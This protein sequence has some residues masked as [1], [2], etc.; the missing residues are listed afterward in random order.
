MLHKDFPPPFVVTGKWSRLPLDVDPAPTVEGLKARGLW[1]LDDIDADVAALIERVLQDRMSAFPLHSDERSPVYAIDLTKETGA[2]LAQASWLGL[3]V[4]EHGTIAMASATRF[5]STRFRTFRGLH[6]VV[7]H[8]IGEQL[9]QGKP[10]VASSM[11]GTIHHEAYHPVVQALQALP[12]VERWLAAELGSIDGG[13]P[14]SFEDPASQDR[15]A[16]Q[17]GR[18]AAQ[19][20]TPVAPDVFNEMGAEALMAARHL[21]PDAPPMAQVWWEAATALLGRA[22]PVAPAL[23][24]FLR[25]LTGAVWHQERSAAG[26]T[27]WLGMLPTDAQRVLDADPDMQWERAHPQDASEIDDRWER[28]QAA[29]ASGEIDR[30]VREGLELAHARVQAL[31]LPDRSRWLP[32]TSPEVLRARWQQGEPVQLSTPWPLG[33]ADSDPL[34]RDAMRLEAEILGFPASQVD[35]ALAAHAAARD[36]RDARSSMAG[37]AA[38]TARRR[39]SRAAMERQSDGHGAADRL[40]PA[41]P[42]APG[43]ASSAKDARSGPPRPKRPGAGPPDRAPRL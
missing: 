37:H 21:G 6:D 34:L 20:S 16:D 38:T 28:A 35:A 14:F 22:S 33:V 32:G 5:C 2:P 40:A 18:Y 17:L 4:G 23:N 8:G 15:I 26:A 30:L 29:A 1:D 39:A 42:P 43:T 11:A 31:Q 9:L 24:Q 13:G 41:Q 25:D 19:L 12:G 27:A 3:D 7:R 10:A 36:Q